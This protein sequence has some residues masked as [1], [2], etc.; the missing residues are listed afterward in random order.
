MTV[1]MTTDNIVRIHHSSYQQYS[2]IARNTIIHLGIYVRD[3]GIKAVVFTDNKD[4]I[5]FCKTV[6][7]STYS[8]PAVNKYGTPIL[9][10]MI[11]TARLKFPSDFVIYINS[12]I[13]INPNFFSAVHRLSSTLGPNV[14]D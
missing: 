10:D 6:N 14:S 4:V 3:L 13:L 5:T 1:I 9:A 2:Q 8:I 11:T 12:D 7:V